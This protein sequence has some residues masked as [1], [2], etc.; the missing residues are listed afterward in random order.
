MQYSMVFIAVQLLCAARKNT[1]KPNTMIEPKKYD[2]K[3]S[4]LALFGSDVEKQV[5]QDSAKAEKA[6]NGA[7]EHVGLQIWRIEQ[8]KV[9]IDLQS[10]T[11]IYCFLSLKVV[12]WPVDL[13]GQLYDG[14]SYILLNTYTQNQSKV[15]R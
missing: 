11:K 14:D 13:Y 4:N 6:W 5:R 7:G 15:T 9:L 2:W 3:D 1:I 12:S 10:H 8:F